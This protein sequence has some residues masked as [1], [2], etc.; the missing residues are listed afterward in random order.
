MSNVIRSFVVRTG[1]DMSGMTV[2]LKKLSTDLKRAGRQIT[3]TGQNLTRN[4]SVPLLAVG[5]ASIKFASDFE[6]GMAKVETIANTATKSIGTLSDEVLSVSNNTGK[7][8][9]EISES[10]YQAISAGADTADAMELVDVASKAAIGGF[11]DTTTAVDGLTS[12]LNAY[13]METTDANKLANLFLITQNKG[14]TTFGELAQ[15]IGNVTAISSTAGVSLEDLLSSI[16][17]LTAN[18]IDTATS[19]TYVK[20]AITSV[21]KPTKEASTVAEQLGLD[22]SAAALQSKGF[23]GFLEDVKEKTG[24]NVETISQLFG[25]VRGLNAVLKL[26]TNE[27]M[28]TMND[29]MGEM[30]TNTTALDDAYETMAGTMSNQF[31]IAI[32]SLK[33]VGIELGQKIMPLVNNGIIPAIKGFAEW[34]G[35]LIDGF[36]NLSP[37]MKQMV[38][39]A[40]GITVAIG[41]LTTIVGKLTITIGSL[42]KSFN[43]ASRAL[44]GGQGLL[45]AITTFLGPAGT[46][47]LAIAAIAAVVGTLVIA[48]NNANAETKALKKEIQDFNETANQSKETFD[49][50]IAKNEASAGA[51]KTLADELYDLADRENKSTIEK[52][53]MADIIDQLNGMYEGLNLILDENTG[54]L[55]L[56]EDAVHGVI[57]AS[58]DMLMLD[59][60]SKRRAELYEEQYEATEKLKSITASMSDEQLEFAEKTKNSELYQQLYNDAMEDGVITTAE[61]KWASWSLVGVVN[62]SASAWLQASMAVDQN[63]EATANATEAYD[64]Q[65]KKVGLTSDIIQDAT[66]QTGIAW[67]DLSDTQKAALKEMGT[68]QA[69]YTAMSEE[70]LQSYL[71]DMREQQEEYEDLLEDR[72]AI[73]QNAFEKIEST[74][75]VSLNEMIDNLESNQKLVDEWTDNLAILTDRGLNEGFIK[76]LEDTGVDAAATVAGLVNA[77]DEEIQRFNDVFENGTTV[78]VESMKKELGL[79]TTV[80]AGSDAISDIA[81]GVKQNKEFKDAAVNQVKGAKSAMA[82]QVRKSNFSSVG[83]SAINAVNNGAWGMRSKLKSTFRQLAKDAVSA[84]KREMRFG[85][86]PKAFVDIGLAI[87]NAVSLGIGETARNA[88]AKVKELSSNIVGA[89]TF[90]AIQ[91]PSMSS[92]DALYSSQMSGLSGSQ[93]VN[94]TTNSNRETNVKVEFTGPVMLG[95]EMD[96]E[97][98]ATMFGYYLQNE[99]I[100]Q[101]E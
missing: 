93:V 12:V 34:L 40:L 73:T 27:G 69:D 72:L 98:T 37:F 81:D 28:A 59:A 33:N 86:P 95:S 32:N 90:D 63:A 21:V 41:P 18:G 77:S 61:L 20:N 8:A 99:L 55:N 83:S 4:L 25:N 68:T 23:A 64:A 45:T 56:N 85:S 3:S 79:S 94:N 78:A 50:L 87:P 54:Q 66:E 30:Q 6:D 43:L 26:T 46:V 89:L 62:G 10:L 65:A 84:M 13:N 82:S 1:V 96:I 39:L 5:A 60:Y 11:T 17:T 53:R 88:V 75:D 16:A 49:D 42:I 19:V 22:F 15:S 97:K 48:F 101:G 44:A 58:E 14:K 76:V 7:A 51:A 38:T 2:G 70:D 71:D 9:T 35:K 31:K 100:A 47:V 29:I 36:E 67:E 57:N 52:I 92:P 80:N 24:G 74:I 91:F